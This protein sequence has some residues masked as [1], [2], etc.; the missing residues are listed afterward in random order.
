MIIVVIC[1]YGSSATGAKHLFEMA[2]PLCGSISRKKK[3]KLTNT[4]NELCG[5]W[6]VLGAFSMLWTHLEDIAGMVV[7]FVL[8]A[9]FVDSS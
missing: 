6:G 5:F 8:H 3:Q 2:K 4:D 9:V 1:H 7:C